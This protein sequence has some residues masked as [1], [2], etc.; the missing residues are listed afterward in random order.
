MCMKM[1]SP[2]AAF[3]GIHRINCYVICFLNILAILF[4]KKLI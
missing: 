3:I 4:G 2:F 1:S